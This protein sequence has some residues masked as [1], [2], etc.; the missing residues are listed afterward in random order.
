VAEELQELKD[1]LS[2]LSSS[3][4][5]LIARQKAQPPADPAPPPPVTPET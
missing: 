4:D 5:E 3:V 1:R 2:D